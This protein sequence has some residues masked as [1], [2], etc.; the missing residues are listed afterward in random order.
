MSSEGYDIYYCENGHL[1]GTF[2]PNMGPEWAN[3]KLICPTCK[4]EKFVVDSVDTTNGCDD[5]CDMTKEDNPCSAHPK[6]L[7]I[8]KYEAIDC[9]K[10]GGI[11]NVA[12]GSLYIKIP[13][14]HNSEEDKK[15]CKKCFGTGVE[16]LVKERV[17]V[18]CPN[19]FGRGK[20]FIPAYDISGFSHK[21]FKIEYY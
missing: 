11:G 6:K 5:N 13:C 14:N 15:I 12:M 17:P 20:E 21:P 16:Y 9:K 3:E 8:I 2:N 4:S 7:K 18:L 19:C 1:V 10:C